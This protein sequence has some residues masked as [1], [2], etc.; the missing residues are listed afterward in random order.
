MKFCDI[1][2]SRNIDPALNNIRTLYT[3]R[4]SRCESLAK[5]VFQLHGVD[6]MGNKVL[7]KRLSRNRLAKFIANLKL[8]LIGMEACGG[9]HYWA[10]AL[11]CPTSHYYYLSLSGKHIFQITYLIITLFSLNSLHTILFSIERTLI[12]CSATSSG[13]KK[14]LKS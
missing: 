6:A 4:T 10:I 12:T 3:N 8:C 14:V 13:F 9:A 5:D 7:S 1:L 2:K 11:H